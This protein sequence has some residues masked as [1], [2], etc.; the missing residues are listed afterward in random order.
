MFHNKISVSLMLFGSSER[1]CIAKGKQIK[2]TINL[3]K[4]QISPGCWT[5]FETFWIMLVHN[6]TK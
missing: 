5:L 1:Y 6:L 4:I 2:C 3:N